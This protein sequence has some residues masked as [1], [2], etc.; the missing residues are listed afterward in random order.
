MSQGPCMS[1]STCTRSSSPSSHTDSQF[2]T[3]PIGATQNAPADASDAPT[4]I[5]SGDMFDAEF[6]DPYGYILSTDPSL[7]VD[8]LEDPCLRIS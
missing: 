8:N 2:S 5:G 7:M 4:V 6:M 1:F 3:A